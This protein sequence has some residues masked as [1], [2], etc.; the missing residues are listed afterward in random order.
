[1]ILVS[2]DTLVRVKAD[3][4]GLEAEDFLS[5]RVVELDH[6]YSGFK[7]IF[8][9]IDLLNQFYE[10]RNLPLKSFLKRSLFT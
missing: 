4:I 6:I 10:Q 3:A 2:K 5:D 8:I 9:S 1:M 7:E